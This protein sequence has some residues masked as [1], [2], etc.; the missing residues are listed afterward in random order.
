MN[1]VL[2]MKRAITGTPLRQYSLYLTTNNNEQ[3]KVEHGII[4]RAFRGA[5]KYVLQMKR[6]ITGTCTVAIFTRFNNLQL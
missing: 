6:A 3:T 4:E 2:P 1:Y 5:W